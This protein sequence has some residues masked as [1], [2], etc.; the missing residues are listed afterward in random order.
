MLNFVLTVAIARQFGA[1]E[2]GNVFYLMSN[3]AF[4]IL[5]LSF[6]LEA[7]I[8]FFSSEEKIKYSKLFHLTLL[9]IAGAVVKIGRAH[10]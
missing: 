3:C 2:S 8:V 1:S 9:W 5:L 10:V 6:S 4:I 7:G